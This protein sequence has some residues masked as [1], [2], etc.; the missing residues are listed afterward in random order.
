MFYIHIIFFKTSETKKNSCSPLIT[1]FPF[2]SFKKIFCE[3]TP[4]PMFFDSFLFV[5]VLGFYLFI[6]QKEQKSTNEGSSRGKGRSRLPIEQAAWCR[7]WS[8]NPRIM[9]W[10]KGKHLTNRATQVS[11]FYDSWIG[12]FIFHELP[13]NENK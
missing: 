13:F 8:Q 5:F 10:A 1:T 4:C 12:F 3:G 6:W 9:T 7:A 11:L 2:C